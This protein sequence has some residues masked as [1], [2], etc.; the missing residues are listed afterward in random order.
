[1]DTGAQKVS[2]ELESN[3]PEL[4]LENKDASSGVMHNTPPSSGDGKAW[5]LNTIIGKVL[6]LLHR[7]SAPWVFNSFNVVILLAILFF[8]ILQPRLKKDNL[9][10]KEVGIKELKASTGTPT[11]A[12]VDL[13]LTKPLSPVENGHTVTESPTGQENSEEQSDVN[14]PEADKELGYADYIKRGNELFECKEYEQALMEYNKATSQSVPFTDEDFLQYRF[15]E[16]YQKI[17]RFDDALAAY[18]NIVTG[19]FRSPYSVR[20]KLR[21]GE[22][23]VDKGEFQKGRKLLFVL[24]AQE[25]KYSDEDKGFVAEAYYKIAESY[26]KEALH[27]AHIQGYVFA[28]EKQ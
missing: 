13:L 27:N 17:G 18:Q 6:N 23:F 4:L 26:M 16:C 8:L 9:T 7:L 10:L 3:S 28:N 25:A 20:A 12:R 14:L 1:M 24:V 5:G 15:G 19:Y 22:C 21:E 2:K 11:E